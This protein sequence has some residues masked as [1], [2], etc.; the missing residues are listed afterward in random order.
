MPPA[1]AALRPALACLLTLSCG[2]LPAEARERSTPEV[3]AQI[4]TR[5][6]AESRIMQ[7]ASTL[8]DVY[9]PRLTGSPQTW[10]A[11]EWA[12]EQ[13]RS[14]G[15]E[16]VHI[17]RWGP[18]GRGWDVERVSVSLLRPAVGP[19]FA[20]P[21][22]WTVGTHGPVRG[23]AIVASLATESDL[24]R[25]HGR[26]QGKIVLL[27]PAVPL[28]ALECP[29]L[30]RLT[31]ADLAKLETPQAPTT[32]PDPAEH[33]RR[34]RFQTEL[35]RFLESEK[36][37]ATIQPG[38]REAGVIM[39]AHPYDF[40]ALQR[41]R[42]VSS[43]VMAGEQYNRLARLV[44]RGS[45]VELE[46]DVETRFHPEGRMVPNTIAEIPGTDR[47][48]EIVMIGAHLDSWHGGTG[49]ADNAA[50]VAVAMEAMR[51]LKVVGAPLRRTVRLALWTGEEQ[52]LLGSRAYVARHFGRREEPKDEAARAI[53][54]F[55]RPRQ[56]HLQLLPG[57]SSLVAYFNMDYGSGRI[58]GV[59]L[60]GNQA[61]RPLLAS[62]LAPLADLGAGTVSPRSLVGSDHQSFEAVGLPAFAF[63]HDDL[64]YAKRTHHTTLDV[65]DRL[66]SEDLVQA[67][68]VAA[69]VLYEAATSDSRPPRPPLPTNH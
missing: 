66:H 31:E 24:V 65:F 54:F 9:G 48:N 50:G 1:P 10:A 41:D 52:G 34:V 55:L 4:R 11:A 49:A 36:V 21:K 3:L 45:D 12:E 47:R 62:W 27:G 57:H 30:R 26:L 43:L 35:V 38:H 22:P 37:L 64:D 28:R 68:I 42:G 6:K 69:S 39:V 29:L 40:L 19:L 13:L 5:A 56:G 14:W 23:S 16:R 8:C 18:F 17:E 60:Q 63:I 46:I 7:T 58:R 61:A 67:S 44:A 20:L 51:L 2:L 59:Y 53:P 32:P 25:Q 15:L 33:L